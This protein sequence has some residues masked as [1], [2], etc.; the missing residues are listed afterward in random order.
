MKISVVV[1]D[2]YADIAEALLRSC[3]D[4]LA[5]EGITVARVA[6]VPGA[7]EIPFALKTVAEEFLNTPDAMVALGCVIRGE[8]YHFQT[9]AD[10]CARGI[11]QVQMQKNIPIGNGVLTVETMAQAR[12]HIGNGAWAARAAAHLAKLAGRG[13]TR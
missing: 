9:V 13:D 6:R 8:T 7:M 12:A 4:A 10:V 3:T 2:F 11:L 5:A 1:A